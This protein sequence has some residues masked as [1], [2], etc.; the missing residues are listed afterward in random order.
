M[1]RLTNQL[2][3]DRHR[4]LKKA[5]TEFRY[6]FTALTPQQQWDLHAYYVLSKDL[7]RDELLAHRQKIEQVRPSLPAASSKHF[8]KLY[9]IF[10]VA[11]EYA[12]GDVIRFG[13][14]VRFLSRPKTI[15]RPA[16]R[17]RSIRV[18]PVVQPDIKIDKLGMAIMMM[19]EEM[20][21]A[22][23]ESGRD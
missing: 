7:N 4:F 17:N 15:A 3:L 13:E 22:N 6:L 16:G 21:R 18:V 10:C 14:A 8:I 20:G 12:E 2:Y 5:W 11:F 1:P 19:A 9:D 23:G